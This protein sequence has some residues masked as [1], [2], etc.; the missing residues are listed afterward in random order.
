MD[1]RISLQRMARMAD[2]TDID[3]LQAF[4]RPS[5]EKRCVAGPAHA[6]SRYGVRLKR[7]GGTPVRRA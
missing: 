6:W 7:P 3:S 5:A 2:T 4:V 1:R